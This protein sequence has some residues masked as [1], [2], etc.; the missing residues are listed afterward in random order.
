MVKLEKGVCIPYGNDLITFN[1]MAALQ[2]G[3]DKKNF[4]RWVGPVEDAI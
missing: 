1:K 2:N 3:L 4:G